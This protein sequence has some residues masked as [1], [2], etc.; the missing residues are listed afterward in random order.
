MH[1]PSRSDT[2]GCATILPSTRFLS[3]PRLSALVR[4]WNERLH[5]E[6]SF[7]TATRHLCRANLLA[8]EAILQE[9]D[10]ACFVQSESAEYFHE[11]CQEY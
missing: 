3:A 7:V 10:D 4:F 5:D 11:G 8:V 1:A 6:K 9:R 2:R